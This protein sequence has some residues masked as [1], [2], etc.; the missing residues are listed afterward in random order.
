MPSRLLVLVLIFAVPLAANAAPV[1]VDAFKRPDMRYHGDGW[2][3]LTPGYWSIKGG[4]LRHRLENVGDDNPI[5]SDPEA[6]IE[7]S[8]I[9]MPERAL[10]RAPASFPFTADDSTDS[11]QEETP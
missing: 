3:S 8:G 11:P 10:G 7:N 6:P 9:C 5:Y 4:A 1:T 2:E